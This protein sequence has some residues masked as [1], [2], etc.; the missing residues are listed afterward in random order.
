MI[1]RV[2][3]AHHYSLKISPHQPISPHNSTS[4]RLWKNMTAKF[5]SRII[6]ICVTYAPEYVYYMIVSYRESS[7]NRPSTSE[8]CRVFTRGQF[9]P[10]GIF[11]GCVGGSVCQCVCVN[12]QLVRTITPRSFKLGSPN[13]DQRCKTPWFRSLL[14]WGMID[15]DLQGPI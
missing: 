4:A 3:I 1:F 12:H 10:S 2:N 5:A 9:W 14:F 7:H 8:I 13:L 15:L 11:I 6:P